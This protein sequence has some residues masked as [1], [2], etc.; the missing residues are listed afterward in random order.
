MWPSGGQR[1]GGSE[2]GHGAIVSTGPADAA[3]I[4]EPR[5]P[6]MGQRRRRR[7]RRARCGDR[8]RGAWVGMCR[9]EAP[10]ELRRRRA[11]GRQLRAI[12]VG[13]RR[14]RRR[15]R[16]RGCPCSSFDERSLNEL[17]RRR[18]S[19][20]DG[21]RG[22]GYREDGAAAGAGAGAA[23]GPATVGRLAGCAGCGAVRADGG[24]RAR[25]RW[26]RDRRQRCDGHQRMKST[27]GG[28]VARGG[29]SE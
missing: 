6:P 28:S 20:E 26:R 16:R 4:P 11:V 10:A 19:R 18:G 15:R 5:Q 24:R 23:A 13:M 8:R 7:Q 29:V 22:D 14:G 17:G 3:T 9:G 12:H 27:D 25:E 1:P 21:Y 2:W